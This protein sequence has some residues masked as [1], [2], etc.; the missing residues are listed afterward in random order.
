MRVWLQGGGVGRC[1]SWWPELRAG[2]LM[3][4]V[5]GDLETRGSRA[6]YHFPL[7]IKPEASIESIPLD[8]LEQNLSPRL[9]CQ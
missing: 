1:C 7:I 8:T 4:S 5:I 9:Q 6:D 2:S 3:T